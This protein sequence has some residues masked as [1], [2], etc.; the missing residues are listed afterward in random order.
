M[1]NHNDFYHDL[2]EGL[3]A[4]CALGLGVALFGAIFGK[5]DPVP[6]QLD[7]ERKRLELAL[8]QAQIDKVNRS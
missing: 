5:S 2:G 7:A 4:G 8:L 1:S 3:V 6:G